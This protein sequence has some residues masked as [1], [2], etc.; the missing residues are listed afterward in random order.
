MS[1]F[2]PSITM[3]AFYYTLLVAFAFALLCS[4]NANDELAGEAGKIQKELSRNVPSADNS[5]KETSGELPPIRWY[6]LE[7]VD[8]DQYWRDVN[9]DKVWIEFVQEKQLTD[10]DVSS[11]LDAHNLTRV[12]KQSANPSASN[13]YIFEH[14]NGT[15]ESVIALVKA[16]KRTDFIRF[17]E[18]Q[19]NYKSGFIPNDQFYE[20]QWGNLLMET[21][22]AYDVVTGGSFNVIAVIDDAVDYLHEDLEMVQYGFDYGF[23]DADPAPDH[24]SQIH[25]THVTGIAAATINNFSGVAG[26]VNDT[27]YFAKVTDENYDPEIGNFSD[28][29]IVDALFDIAGIDRVGVVNLSLGGPTPSAAIEQACAT[30][31]NAGKLLVAASGNDG[32]EVIG[33]PAAF[34]SCMA[35]GALGTD[36]YDLYL[37]PYSQFGPEQE[38]VA[39]G[40]D[41]NTG[42][43]ILSTFPNNDYQSLQGTSMATP[44]VAGLAGMMMAANPNLSAAEVREC[45]NASAVD[46]GAPGFDPVFGNG[47]IYP[48][49]ALQLATNG[50]SNSIADLESIGLSAFPNPTSDRIVLTRENAVSE[51]TVQVFD[52]KGALMAEQKWIVG[53]KQ[54]TIELT[55]FSAGSYLLKLKKDANN[56]HQ[57]IIIKQ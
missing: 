55:D 5:T 37:A 20:F 22:L 6:A 17:A 41:E 50:H 25:G 7:N 18:P 4:C 32:I 42:F 10:D 53:L 43:G 31:A 40:G 39:P 49:Q 24:P 34:P 45:I 12:C 44:Y 2:K 1:L 30:C 15:R 26:M 57:Q 14:P 13:Y 46:A 29:A 48:P 3:K 21:D 23:G 8:N 11:F 33:F 54:N 28:A 35:V 16:A 27:V 52:L 51:L 47:I 36:G 9:T 19:S 38:V 56:I